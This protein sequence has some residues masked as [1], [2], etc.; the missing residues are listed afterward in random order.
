MCFALFL[1]INYSREECAIKA[2]LILV[3]LGCMP[4]HEYVG[5]KGKLGQ[6]LSFIK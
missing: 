2:I 3:L 1:P 5:G 4:V 6:S